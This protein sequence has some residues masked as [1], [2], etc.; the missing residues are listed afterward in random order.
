MFNKRSIY[1][2]QKHILYRIQIYSQLL[3][4]EMLQ[5]G[6]FT[7]VGFII[8]Y[9]N[10]NCQVTLKLKKHR[11]FTNFLAVS[12]SLHQH[13][14]SFLKQ[15]LILWFKHKFKYIKYKLDKSQ[16]LIQSCR[17][18]ANTKQIPDLRS[19]KNINCKIV[20]ILNINW[21]LIIIIITSTFPDLH[22]SDKMLRHLHTTRY[23]PC[24]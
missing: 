4:L 23:S 12:T 1:Y 8:R 5:F 17:N 21:T 3:I 24:H 19:Y 14:H 18:I 15:F 9:V 2:I 20:K 10:L 13:C 7:E 11:F 6:L 16:R 22:E